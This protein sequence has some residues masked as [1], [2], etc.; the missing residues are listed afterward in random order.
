M[1]TVPEA[2]GPAS[3]LGRSRDRRAAHDTESARATTTRARGARWSEHAN[4]LPRRGHA[5]HAEHRRG[6]GAGATAPQDGHRRM[7]GVRRRRGLRRQR[8][9]PPGTSRTPSPSRNGGVR[10]CRRRAAHRVQARLPRAG[11]RAGPRRRR[12]RRCP[13]RRRARRH[14]SPAR[15][16]A[17]SDLRRPLDAGNAGQLSGDGRSALVVFGVRGTAGD[18][19]HEDIDKVDPLLAATVRPP[20]GRTRRC[21]FGQSG[22]RERPEGRGEGRS[23][24]TSP[25]RRSSRCRSRWRSSSSRSGRSRGGRAVAARADGGHGHDGARRDPEP[26]RPCG[27]PDLGGSCSCRDAVGVDYA[28]FYLRREREERAAG[29]RR[30]RGARGGGRD[31]GPVGPRLRG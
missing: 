1:A 14:P 9:R 11:A 2:R 30:G 18:D 19:R 5:Q 16:G 10:S 23:R 15:T 3:Y 28:L 20:L 4:E 26:D 17:A 7:A 22:R 27:Q 24:T 12:S 31:V 25:R 13:A 8:H 6:A 29:C 21:G